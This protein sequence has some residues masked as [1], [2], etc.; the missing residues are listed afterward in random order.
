MVWFRLGGTIDAPMGRTKEDV[1]M[2]V[3]EPMLR[4]HRNKRNM[5][6]L[7]S[8]TEALAA[9]IECGIACQACSD[10]CMAEVDPAPLLRCMRTSSD[11]AVICGATASVL[12][13]TNDP[14]WRVIQAQLSACIAAC[15]ACA[16][17]CDRHVRL[18][19]CRLCA[20][21]CWGALRLC[22]QIRA[23]IR[24]PYPQGSQ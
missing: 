24:A 16:E 23:E 2:S 19:H 1:L 18:R 9:L 15:T 6:R 4:S 14:D 8:H 22:E 11:C 5:S 17:E 13:R 21:S 3:V 20:T 7:G 12:S 10:A